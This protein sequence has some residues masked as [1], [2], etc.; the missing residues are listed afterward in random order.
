[1]AAGLRA[2]KQLV[3][4]LKDQDFRSIPAVVA[5]SEIILKEMRC[6]LE[7]VE[8]LGKGDYAVGT[9][10][11]FEAGVLDVPFAPSRYNAGKVMPARDNVG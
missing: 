7:K 2:S 11:A 8:E 1:N 3:S 9:V 6:I 5:E 4:M 10:A